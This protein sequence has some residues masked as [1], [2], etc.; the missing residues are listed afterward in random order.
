MKTNAMRCSALILLGA[1]FING[2][3]PISIAHA[4]PAVEATRPLVSGERA[5]VQRLAR[6]IASAAE[7][8]NQG[9]VAP[10]QD[11]AH[12]QQ[13]QDRIDRFRAAL[14]RF[15]QTDDPDV[16]AA[17]AALADL[18][19]LFTFA[20]REGARQR[21]KTGDVQATLAA[22]DKGLR[23]QRAPQWLPVPFTE[24]EANRWVSNAAEAKNFATDAIATVQRIA[25]D[26][27]LPLTRG[28]VD[29]GA[30]YDRQDLTRLLNVANRTVRNV[31]EAVEQTLANLRSA[32]QGQDRELDYY[33]SLDPENPSHRM[34]AFLAGD[35][36]ARV[37]GE[38]D[39]QLALA[40][41]A[42][43]LQR[44]FG[45]EPTTNTSARIEE[46]IALRETYAENRLR[47]I[48]DST[49]PE[50]KSDDPGRI[51]IAQEILANPRYEFGEHGPV[52]LTT[53][54]IVEREKEVSRAEIKN[55]EFSLS[56]DITLS[57]TETTWHYRW[58]EFN[59]ATPIRDDDSDDWYVWW[60]TARKYDSG[61]ERTPIGRWVSG[62]IVKGDLILPENF[63]R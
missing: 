15:P 24:E 40:R 60:I 35:A 48:G 4:E 6:D 27:H 9:G 7:T 62:A 56:G 41:S 63:G 34:N 61:W 13:W 1:L 51:A 50:A 2:G 52:V 20:A 22:I 19:N 17:A 14:A 11:P 26:A 58:E 47:A 42:A 3:P 31:D 55:L 28:T 33:R 16:Q 57:G 23:A 29:Q 39:R 21:A 37:Y 53:P 45:Q 36:P 49:L 5:R 18:E 43:A 12:V 44:A 46:I 10:F 25:A 59:F 38:L 32:F 30:A 54:E 8:L